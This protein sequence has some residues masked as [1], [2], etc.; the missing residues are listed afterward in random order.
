MVKINFKVLS[1]EGQRELDSGLQEVSEPFKYLY[2]LESTGAG[3]D[4]LP[5]L[6]SL[7]RRVLNALFGL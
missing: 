1:L 4:K 5:F 3:Q 2:A 6:N 7:V